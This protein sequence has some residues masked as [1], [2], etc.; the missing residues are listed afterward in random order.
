[1]NSPIDAFEKILKS[2]SI[3]RLPYPLGEQPS[4]TIRFTIGGPEPIYLADHREPNGTYVENA[5][6]RLLSLVKAL[7]APPDLLRIDLDTQELPLTDSLLSRLHL[8]QPDR[9]Q[10][11]PDFQQAC[12]WQLSGD[13]EDLRHLLREII[14]SEISPEGLEGLCG[15][16]YLAQRDRNLL[17]HPADDRFAYVA[18]ADAAG[19][20]PL[21]DTFKVWISPQELLR[22]RSLFP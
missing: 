21:F 12:Y 1:M 15:T 17:V 4:P 19:L 6:D 10:D 22:V 18:C 3:D 7:P 16:V 9:I 5:L 14:R 8:P 11:L 20:R 13:P 2:L